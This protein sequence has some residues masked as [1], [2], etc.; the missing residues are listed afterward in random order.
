MALPRAATEQTRPKWVRARLPILAMRRR[1]YLPALYSLDGK[2]LGNPIRQ[3]QRAETCIEAEVEP[4]PDA[5]KRGL[6]LTWGDGTTT[7]AVARSVVVPPEVDEALMV[8]GAGN[9]PAPDAL[10][11]RRPSA[12]W[13]APQP[14]DAGDVELAEL[15][16]RCEEVRASWHGRFSWRQERQEDGKVIERGLRPPQVGALHAALAHWT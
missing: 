11:E 8:P 12:H 7:L 13:L 2:V 15:E 1:V 16:T 10:G 9:P 6:L 14:L 3:V 4:Y 5:P